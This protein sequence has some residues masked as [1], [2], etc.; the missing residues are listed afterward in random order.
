MDTLMQEFVEQRKLL[1]KILNFDLNLG[2]NPALTIAKKLAR[3]TT[4]DIGDTVN[5][6]VATIMLLEFKKFLF[7]CALRIINGKVT[8]YKSTVNGRVI[9]KCPFPAPPMINKAWDLVILY[10]DNYIKLCD[11][12]FGGFLD[13]PQFVSQDEEFDAYDYMYRLLD[14]KR[15][16]LHPFWNFWPKYA[17]KEFYWQEKNLMV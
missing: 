9:I 8:D 15:R 4:N 1:S 13:K 6:T 2:Q 11:E 17:M 12:I 5:I 7:L 3:E 16:V 10:S 14:R